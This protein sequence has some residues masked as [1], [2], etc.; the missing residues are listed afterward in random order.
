MLRMWENWRSRCFNSLYYDATLNPH[1]SPVSI[2]RGRGKKETQLSTWIWA[3][4]EQCMVNWDEK[5]QVII[6]E[7]SEANGGRL[8]L[9][10]G[11]KLVLSLARLCLSPAADWESCQ[12]SKQRGHCRLVVL[13]LWSH[14]TS[15]PI[16]SFW[17]IFLTDWV[18]C[19]NDM[20]YVKP[21]L[22]KIKVSFPSWNH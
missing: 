17:W 10:P 20:V 12:P 6:S 4:Q 19:L 2:T 3:S 11:N 18:V 7:E 9:S 16:F 1:F 5:T 14:D 21:Q 15:E 22:Q 8:S 13:K